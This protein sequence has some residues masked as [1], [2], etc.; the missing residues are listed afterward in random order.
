MKDVKDA[1]VSVLVAALKDENSAVRCSAC[2]A[3]GGTDR[4]AV[5]ILLEALKDDDTWVRMTAT[6][7]L[8]KII[9]RNAFPVAP[10]LI[11]LFNKKNPQAYRNERPTYANTLGEIGAVSA[12]PSLIAGLSDE[13]AMVRNY[14]ARALGKIGEGAVSAV[15]S[16]IAALDDED[17]TVRYN[18]SEALKS[19][20][21][22]AIPSLLAMF[23]DENCLTREHILETFDEIGP[24]AASAVAALVTI[25]NDVA[26]DK[27]RGNLRSTAAKILGEIATDAT[28]VPALIEAVKG[29]IT[30]SHVREPESRRLQESQRF[31]TGIKSVI[32]LGQLGPLAVDAVPILMTKLKSEPTDLF[33]AE[34]LTRIAPNLTEPFAFIIAA[35]KHENLNVRER[36][37]A[38]KTL[39]RI[40]PRA[41][42]T[43]SALTTAL[44]DKDTIVR[45]EVAEAL[46]QIGLGAM[47]AVPALV[48][49]LQDEE[50]TVR[51]SI[52]SALDSI[53]PKETKMLPVFI[54]A[55]ND[56]DMQVRGRAVYALGR[57]GPDAVTAVPALMKALQGADFWLHISV[58]DALNQIGADVT[59]VILL[60]AEALSDKDINVRANA[61]EALGKIGPQASAAVPRLIAALTEGMEL[62]SQRVSKQSA[63]DGID[64]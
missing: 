31:H 32:A 21:P 47:A 36:R 46:G 43:V 9:G 59:A 20:G 33:I 24:D 55:L 8:G 22:H 50:A 35:L 64:L 26:L 62:K 17:S 30:P 23:K 34:A 45:Q 37:E 16:L 56:E 61:A 29:L 51:C 7:A 53:S 39:G 44:K 48:A 25:L 60:L 1:A 27:V 42:A 4:S 58:A 52:V 57:R 5:A 28:A 11:A 18:A 14:A 13:Q 40:G 15:P 10:V 63:Q 3:L 2:E 49:A 6:R 41:V 38:A 54:T 12:V 19:F